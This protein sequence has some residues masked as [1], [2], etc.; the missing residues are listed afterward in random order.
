MDLQRWFARAWARLRAWRRIRFTWGGLVFTLGAGAVGFAAVNTGNNLLYLL[1][2]AM[3][4]IIAVSGWF[5]ERMIRDLEITRRVPRGVTV[6]HDARLLYEV[7]SHRRRMPTLAVEIGEQG[8]SERA[9]IARL[10]AGGTIRTRSLN[11]FI[12]RGTYPLSTLTLSTSFPFGLFLK[13]RDISLPGELVIWPRSDRPVR[14]PAPAAGRRRPGAVAAVGSPGARG[15][16]RGLREYR[17]GDDPRDIHWKTSARSPAPVVREYDADASEDLWICLDSGGEPGDAAEAAIEVAASLAAQAAR[18]GRRFG[19]V[20]AD[21]QIA[22]ASGP[23]HLE[24]ALDTLARVD[25]HRQAPAPS[26][27]VDPARC[28]LVSVSGRGSGR[29]ADSYLVSG[30]VGGPE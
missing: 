3:L 7:K 25:F 24:L 28:V 17:V 6:G 23:G 8:L 15:E 5:S 10:P 14:T 29:Y 16:Y 18:E 9:F 19:L 4:G 27:P 1:L 26:P 13:E 12:K 30:P 22:P 11:R 21:R 2:G 20:T